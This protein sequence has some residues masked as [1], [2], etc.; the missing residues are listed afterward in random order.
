MRVERIRVVEPVREIADRRE[1]RRCEFWG[2]N[3]PTKDHKAFCRF[4][5]TQTPY[6]ASLV[7]EIKRRESRR[8]QQQARKLRKQQAPKRAKRK[9]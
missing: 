1:P 2:C 4:H 6:A 8:Q 3:Q 9:G 7:K 5:I